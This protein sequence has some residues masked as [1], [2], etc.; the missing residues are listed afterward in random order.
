M[1]DLSKL[2]YN[3]NG[4][5]IRDLDHL[6]RHLHIRKPKAVLV[7]DNFDL[8][9]RIYDMLEGKTI[10]I[11]REYTGGPTGEGAEWKRDSR[12][13]ADNSMHIKHPEIYRYVKGNEPIYG[14][15]LP[16]DD[17]NSV[18]ALVENQVDTFNLLRDGGYH[19]VGPNFSVGQPE[20]YEF[21]SG[22][23]DPLLEIFADGWHILGLHE[24][25]LAD[26]DKTIAFGL[27]K[28]QATD[29]LNP[30]TNDPAHWLT[31]VPQKRVEW[32]GQMVMP[33]TFWGLRGIWWN[34][35]AD[36]LKINRPRIILTE[37]LWDEITLTDQ[38]GHN[39][40]DALKSVWGT[41]GRIGI[42]GP[43]G[44]KSIWDGMFKRLGWSYARVFME[45]VKHFFALAPDNYEACTLFAWNANELWVDSGSDISDQYEILDAL[46]VESVT[47]LPAPIP[48]PEPPAPTPHPE[49]PASPQIGD[50]S[51][52]I[53]GTPR[54]VQ[55][56]I[57]SVDPSKVKPYLNVRSSPEIADNKVGHIVGS[58]SAAYLPDFTITASGYQWAPVCI[59]LAED[60][61][62]WVW[63]ALI[64]G[65][66]LNGERKAA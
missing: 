35:R 31:E 10:V 30:Q 61:W 62:K 39:V 48:Q 63:I 27:G 42:S 66:S 3:I 18:H 50:L 32:D 44:L 64:D 16:K 17:P 51:V 2:G 65:V 59:Q 38:G 12:A 20:P 19:G 5:A 46:E 53:N 7:M 14:H 57:L 26:V 47:A 21:D 24:Y 22:D 40:K 9:L 33:G 55:L 28:A 13:W 34:I 4:Q 29:F 49:P 15:N 8:C 1:T 52:S 45:Q 60:D 23:L 54:K 37:G 6:L 58:Y 25:M 43:A 41:N 56:G 36:E 11:H